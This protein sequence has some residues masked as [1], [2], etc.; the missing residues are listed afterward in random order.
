MAELELAGELCL[1][2]APPPA[3]GNPVSVYLAGL[4]SVES[5]RGMLLSLRT[6]IAVTEGLDVREVPL[7]A[8]YR[9]PWWRLRV[10]HTAA[11]R[12]ALAGRYQPASA[13]RHLAALRGVLKACWQLE[14]MTTD[15]YERARHVG[16][17]RGSGLLRGRHVDTG[18]V[19]A[20]VASCRADAP[21]PAGRR[22]AAL[23]ALMFGGGLRRTEI[24]A[25][26]LGDY[27]PETGW[28][29][30]RHGKGRKARRVALDRG[31]R[32]ALDDW[33]A[34]RGSA[35]GPLVC[36][37][38]RRRLRVEIR[39]LSAQAVYGATVRRARLAGVRPLSPHDGRRTVAG[40]LL[41][42]GADLVT[43]QR[44]LGHAS[45]D[46]TARYDRRGDR[47]QERAAGL[48]HFP[49]G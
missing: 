43:V 24:V 14:L 22:D 25:L 18:E 29:A 28:L 13:N 42:R 37:L 33:L 40:E 48:L 27:E 2:D 44:R 4:E 36:P 32:A 34:L 20:M 26:D 41:E 49:W 45:S 15:A 17:V 47:A 7:E 11:I 21:R 1:L 38:D 39:R 3:P 9:F 30:V 12:A 46:T 35:P 8:A 5:R 10:H 16:R 6:V 19:V 31:A 23:L